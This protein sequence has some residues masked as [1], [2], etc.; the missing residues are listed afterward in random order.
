MPLISVTTNQKVDKKTADNLKAACGTAI[1]ILPGKTERWLMVEIEGEKSLYFAGTDEPCAI[2]SVEILGKAAPAVYETM[3]A[4]M[5]DILSA[6]LNVP[7]DR[8]YVKYEEISTWGW[9]GTNF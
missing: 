4:A 3:T 8:V 7:K 5:C 2:A 6:A 9:N 1:T